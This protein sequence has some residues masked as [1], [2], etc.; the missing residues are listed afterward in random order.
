MCPGERRKQGSPQVGTV[1]GASADLLVTDK[2]VLDACC[3]GRMMWFDKQHPQTL[4]ID[5]RETPKGYCA[6]RPNFQVKPDIILDFRHLPFP[7][8]TFKLIAWDP[9][10]WRNLSPLTVIGKFYGALNSATWRDDLAKGFA[11]LWRVLDNNGTLIFK[12]SDADIPLKEVLACFKQQPLFGH[13]TGAKAQTHWVCF[14]KHTAN[15]TTR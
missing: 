11:E 5:V 12:W 10:H 13:K 3:G 4:Y 7:D 1:T 14:F 2:V 8:A 15:E 9:P 6:Y